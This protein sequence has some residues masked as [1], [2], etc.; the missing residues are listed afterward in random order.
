MHLLGVELA[1]VTRLDDGG[2]VLEHL[3]PIKAAPEDL[4]SKGAR[5]RVVAT[6]ATVDVSDEHSSFLRGYALERD[7]IWAF[8]VQVPLED[9]I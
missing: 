7:S 1:C 6:F 8:P 2:G 4:A 9:E 3:R 5:R